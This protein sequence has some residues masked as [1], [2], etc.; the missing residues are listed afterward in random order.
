MGVISHGV[1][2]RRNGISALIQDP[3]ELPR[4]RQPPVSQGVCW[5][6]D[7]G[8]PSLGNW[9]K[10]TFALQATQ[11]TLFLLQQPEKSETLVGC[12]V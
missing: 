9:G 8:L 6:L 7:L 12:S 1:G 2:A 10:A 11:P 4:P 5:H 3:R